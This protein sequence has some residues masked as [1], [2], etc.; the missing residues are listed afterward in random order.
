MMAENTIQPYA[1]VTEKTHPAVLD[2][3]RFLESQSHKDIS[4]FA[5]YLSENE[6]FFLNLPGGIEITDPQAL[7]QMHQHLYASPDFSCR[8]EELQNGI[9]NDD[10]FTCSVKVGVTFPGGVKRSNYIDMTF[11]KNSKESPAWVPIRLINTV[12]D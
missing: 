2:I 5:S 8:F 11:V 10:F 1:I 9:G 12:I 7:I 3:Q 6:L 4:V